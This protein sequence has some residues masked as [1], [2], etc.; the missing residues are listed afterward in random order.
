MTST[1]TINAI[2]GN[3]HIGVP[4]FSRFGKKSN[5]NFLCFSPPRQTADGDPVLKA[6][7][8]KVEAIKKDSF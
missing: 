8:E 6:N 4:V 7:N 1:I 5:Y 2:E 3:S